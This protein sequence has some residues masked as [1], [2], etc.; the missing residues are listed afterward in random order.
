MSPP[1]KNSGDTTWLSVAITM[2]PAPHRERRLVVGLAQPFVVE[3]AQE[4]LVDQL[5]HRAAAA[6]VRHVD[7]PVLEVDG[8][9]VAVAHR[10]HAA[11]VAVPARRRRG[12][13]LN[14]PYV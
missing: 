7:V 2:R 6:A 13:S 10:A 12:T 14:R 3:R 1:G 4:Q 11:A 8:P 5:R 9:D